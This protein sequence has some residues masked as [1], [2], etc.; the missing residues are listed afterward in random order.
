[1]QRANRKGNGDTL[2][3]QLVPHISAHRVVGFID[4]GVIAHVEFDLIGHGVIGEVDQEHFD[5]RIRNNV[6][7]A[8]RGA[9]QRVFHKV[10]WV[11][12]FNANTNPHGM[13]LGRIVQI[14]DLVAHHLVVRDVEINVVVGTQPR[15]T[16]VDLTHLGVR[17][18][19]LQP[20]PELVG[21][22]NV[23]RYAADDSGEQILPGETDD[24]CNDAGARQQSFQLCFGVITVAQDKEQYKQEN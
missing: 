3:L 17:V 24:D 21:P 6:F 19:H 5:R 18:A 1:M 13:D 11:L 15:G 12:V 2:A 20:V 4:P 8:L 22:V 9:P 7:S 14:D 23:N 10:G 16:P